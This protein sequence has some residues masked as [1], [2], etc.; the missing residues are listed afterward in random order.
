MNPQRVDIFC[1]IVHFGAPQP[2]DALIH[3]LCTGTTIPRGIIVVDHANVPYQVRGEVSAVPVRIVRASKNAGYAA[4]VNRGHMELAKFQ[5]NTTDLIVACNNDVVVRR[6]TIAALLAWWRRQKQ[7]VLAAHRLGYVNLVTGR[8]HI[9]PIATADTPFAVPYA[10]GSFLAASLA[11]WRKIGRLPETYF[12]YWEDAAVSMQ[13]HGAG[14]ALVQVPSIGLRHNDA[15]RPPSGQRKY[16]L[17]RNGAAF[18]ETST[19]GMWPL[20]WRGIN[21]MRQGYHALCGNQA[22]VK[23]LQDR[24]QL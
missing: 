10:H 17:I 6:H 5:A 2:T 22:V 18:L 14:V 8:A 11:T 23:A 19:P 7:P 15:S 3:G 9:A 21:I 4:G 24:K 12:L 13:A 1:I 20:Y 16:Y